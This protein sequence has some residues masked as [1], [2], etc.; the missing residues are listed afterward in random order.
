MGWGR[1]WGALAEEHSG[2]QR[3]GVLGQSRTVPTPERSCVFVCAVN[4]NTSFQLIVPLSV[5]AL[6]S[7]PQVITVTEVLVGDFVVCLSVPVWLDFVPQAAGVE[8]HLS[9]CTER[10]STLSLSPSVR[11]KNK[12]KPA[13]RIHRS[14]R[15][16]TCWQYLKTNSVSAAS[17]LYV[18]REYS[19]VYCAGL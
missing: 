8:S 11:G 16:R 5:S 14:A 15:P 2:W 13:L 12:P 6:P 1:T 9:V 17:S 19:V 10:R 3:G 4:K 18:N 7:E